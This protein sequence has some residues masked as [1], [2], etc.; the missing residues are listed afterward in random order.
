VNV[1]IFIEVFNDIRAC[2]MCFV[3]QTSPKKRYDCPGLWRGVC[4]NDTH[5]RLGGLRHYL[6]SE[7]GHP[8]E[9][10]KQSIDVRVEGC[11][12]CYRKLVVK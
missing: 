7:S 2:L 9:I 8:Q 12:E 11:S 1:E 6:L 4:D 10:R 3:L 5:C